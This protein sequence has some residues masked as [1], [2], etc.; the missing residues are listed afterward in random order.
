MRVEQA[1]GEIC[2][3]F[4]F[5]LYHT[6][7]VLDAGVVLV[8]ETNVSYNSTLFSHVVQGGYP[9]HGDKREFPNWLH[10]LDVSF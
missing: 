8:D 9:M 2:V 4:D 10:E 3:T 6:Q 5:E 7:Y 1:Y